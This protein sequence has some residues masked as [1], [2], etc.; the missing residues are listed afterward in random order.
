MKHKAFISY[1][2]SE[3]SRAQALSLERALKRYAKPLLKPP[4]SIFRDEQILRPGDDLPSAIRNALEQ[5]EFLIYLASKEA[6][7]SPW[8]ADEL[9]IWCEVLEHTDRLIIVH[10]ADNIGVDSVN[11]R[12]DWTRTDA[13]PRELEASL[14]SL[15]LYADLCWATGDEDRDLNNTEV[16][17]MVFLHG[18]I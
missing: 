7:A 6:A 17:A 1:R 9:S 16:P 18:S 5:S 4:M 3:N 14:K 15:P 2:H 10:I 13:V 12:I 8:I 11:Q